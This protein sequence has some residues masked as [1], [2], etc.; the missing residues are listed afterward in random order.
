MK[1]II[2]V[3][4]FLCY[5]CG[6]SNLSINKN[7]ETKNL[8]KILDSLGIC[9]NIDSSKWNDTI[10]ENPQIINEWGSFCDSNYFKIHKF[11]E[12]NER[13]NFFLLETKINHGSEEYDNY[14]IS[15]YKGN[16]IINQEFKGYFLNSIIDDSGKEQRFRYKFYITEKSY[17]IVVGK[18]KFN[19]IV[20]DSIEKMD[21]AFKNIF[22]KGSVWK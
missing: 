11:I 21:S 17:V 12:G 18:L 4:I 22:Y 19:Q 14:L 5:S 8:Y 10:L 16:Y 7:T 6:N 9:L 3:L 1:I 15:F 20:T 2:Y 13:L